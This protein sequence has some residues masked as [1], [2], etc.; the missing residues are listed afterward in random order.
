MFQVKTKNSYSLYL[1]RVQQSR[2]CS[3]KIEFYRNYNNVVSENFHSKDIKKH[4]SP[5]RSEPAAR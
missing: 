4:D 3:V 5:K 1:L 2:A